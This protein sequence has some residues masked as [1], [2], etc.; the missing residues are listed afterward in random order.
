MYQIIYNKWDVL[1]VETIVM[2]FANVVEF[3]A[4]NSPNEPAIGDTERLLTYAVL[5]QESDVVANALATLGVEPGDRIAICLQNR[6]EF[7]VLYLGMMKRGAIP[8]PVNTQFTDTQVRYVIDRCDASVFVTD[9]AF[10][11]VAS[12]IETAIT[13]DGNVGHDYRTLLEEAN[14]E[15]VIHPRRDDET[16]AIVF[17]SGTTGR[18][19]GVHHTHGNIHANARGIIRYLDLT[20]EDVGL[21]V[22][23]CFHVTGLN[24]TTTPLVV[25]EAE[26]RLLS[27][28]NP[29]LTLH[30]IEEHEV[31]FAFFTPNMMTE[32]L[33]CNDVNGYDLS[34]LTTVGVGGAP[35]PTTHLEAAEE[36]LG[37]AVLQGY[38]MTE[39]TPLAAF[40]RPDSG[41]RKPD[42]VG[43]PA[44]EVVDLRVEDR[45][46]G[47]A[48]DCE[49]R[50]E[51]LWR[52]DTVTSGYE[53]RQNDTDAF[54][55]RDG[56][57][58]FRSG[59]IGWLDED[60]YLFIVDRREDMFVTGCA[61]VS[62]R[63]IE[64]VLYELDGV[65]KA[66]VVDTRDDRRGAVVTAVIRCMDDSLSV[67]RVHAVCEDR[68]E[69]HEVP[70]RIEFVDEIP[71]TV[72]GKID[73]A[74]L[75][76]TVETRHSY[77]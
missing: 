2:N 77:A 70:Q 59:D 6:V 25:L 33:E 50:G 71:M 5:S 11:T 44:R 20:R 49:E 45:T 69:K 74:A 21:T 72:T 57:R 41:L 24:V 32:L 10:E 58:W 19:K 55:E 23:Q 68:L 64:G 66:A 36:T 30:T 56:R 12:G 1:S 47:E 37:C 22:C 8:V 17:T 9:E 73:R 43:S 3:A 62:P 67:D 40:E 18:P 52:G 39:T 34:S 27:D 53:H 35:I 46:T 63:K 7:L 13:V 16:A 51:L 26:N 28:W 29:E 4:A 42:S 54:V 31:T 15:C 75:R 65:T 14:N 60:D 61:N 48:V 76:K 38:G